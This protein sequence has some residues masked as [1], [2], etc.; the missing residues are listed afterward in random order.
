[1]RSG[2]LTQTQS[3]HDSTITIDIVYV[4]ILQQLTTT[5]YHLGQRTSGSIVLV[6]LLQVLRQVLD[7]IGEQCDLALCATSISSTL[8]KLSEDLYLLCLIEIYNCLF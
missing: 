8:A 4:E 2:L 3:L 1:M 7:T 5:T 6:I